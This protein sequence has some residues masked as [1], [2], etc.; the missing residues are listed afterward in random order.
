[1]REAVVEALVEK[2]DAFL[3][4]RLD[5]TENHKDSGDAYS[6]LPR[7]GGFAYG[8]G[9]ARLVR[10]LAAQGIYP[11]GLEPEALSEIALEN[12]RMEAGSILDPSSSDPEIFVIDNYPIGEIELQVE[13]DA[14]DPEASDAEWEQAK[15]DAQAFFKGNLG[16]MTSDRVWYAVIEAKTLRREIE[17]ATEPEFEIDF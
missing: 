13:K 7:E 16:Y 5:W 17:R 6:H 14:F 11:Q 9:E 1:M 2:L 12:F 4:T 8:N 3:E 10:F 15:K